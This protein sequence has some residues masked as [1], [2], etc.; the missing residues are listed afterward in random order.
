[1]TDLA[2]INKLFPPRPQ[3]QGRASNSVENM[4]SKEFLRLMVAQ[5][6]NQD[7]TK[8][9][10]NTEFV[11]QLAQFGTVSGVQELNQGFA[12]LAKAFNASHAAGLV[13]RRVATDSNLGHLRAVGGE[14]RALALTATVKVEG[15]ASGATVYVQDMQGRLVHKA[16][17]PAG[18]S[19]DLPFSWNG[20][21]KNG[22]R[23]PLGSYR[24][25]A[26]AQVDG[27]PKTLSVFA[28]QQV[29]SVAVNSTTGQVTLNLSN[30]RSVP[31]GAVRQ[32]L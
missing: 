31:P 30:G 12:T 18:A 13:G 1:M 17:L 22:K 11:A 20:L 8:P 7:P 4:G 14:G 2:A 24:V 10:D 29:L 15:K 32:F 25:S 23:L 27:K 21:D 9:I 16:L 26:T 6:K 5:L 28:H 3:A 19:G